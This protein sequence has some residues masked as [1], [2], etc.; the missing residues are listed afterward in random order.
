MIGLNHR[1]QLRFQTLLVSLLLLGACSSHSPYTAGPFE[2]KD[3]APGEVRDWHNIPDAQPKHEPRARYGNHSPYEVFGKTYYVMPSAHGYRETGIGSWY[4]KKFSGRPTSSQEPY[5]PYAMT[6]AHKTLPLPSYVRVT[7]LDN[8]KQIIVRVNDRGPFHGGRIIDLSYAAAHKIGYANQGTARVLVEAIT[9][10]DGATPPNNK[11]SEATAVPYAPPKNSAPAAEKYYIQVGAYR[12]LSTAKSM[13]QQLITVTN[14]PVGIHSS[15][16]P[17]SS[18]VH[19]VRVGPFLT[20][21][22]AM[23][24]Q[25]QLHGTVSDPLLIRR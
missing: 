7:N 11:Q 6:A 19:R 14:A 15:P 16:E 23:T 5:D 9:V 13:Q 18:G 10:N 24:V 20:E 1:S 21:Q 3:S 25:N 8:N 22:A 17:G 2:E 12:D 4:G